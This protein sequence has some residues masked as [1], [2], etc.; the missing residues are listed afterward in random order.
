MDSQ[1]ENS[2]TR[3]IRGST[4]LLT[5]R[6]CSLL[7]NFFTQVLTVRYLSRQDYGVFAYAISLV[8]LMALASAFGM[9]KTFSQFAAAYHEQ[10]NLRRLN[11]ALIFSSA[12]ILGLGS[13]LIGGCWLGRGHLFPWLGI[14]QEEAFVLM[15]LVLL[16]PFGGFGSLASS[17]FAVMGETRTVFYRRQIIGPV[18][19]CLA[20]VTGITLDGGLKGVALAFLLAGLIQFVLDLFLMGRFALKYQLLDSLHR[21]RPEIPAR[22]FL[23]F[24]L[25]VLASD[26][27]TMICGSLVIVMVGMFGGS[28]EAAA[29][30]VVQPLVRLCELPPVTFGILF[31]PLASRLMIRNRP[32]ELREIYLRTRTWVRVLTFPIFAVCVLLAEPVIQMLFGVEYLESGR[33]M[34]ILAIGFYV[35][36]GFG[37][38]IQLLKILRRIRLAVTIDI[39]GALMTLGMCLLL[40]PQWQAI[41]AAVGVSLG[42]VVHTLLRE[43]ALQWVFPMG[44]LAQGLNFVNLGT[45]FC[46]LGVIGLRFGLALPTLPSLLLAIGLSLYVF[47]INRRQL[48]VESMFPE[49][50]RFPLLHRLLAGGGTPVRPETVGPSTQR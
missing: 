43:F 44:S 7:L 38:N 9:D 26:A 31:T 5:G 12:I 48:Q 20:M 36:A 30:R 24:G 23:G 18:L 11:G 1:G 33:V 50:G 4:L 32:S 49:L 40:I 34:A 15:L 22:E 14:N 17:F 13:L 45:L 2:S 39:L 16:V 46:V 35:E 47:L 19:K 8:E 21:E 6:G 3:Q 41:G 29:F 42:M 27:S 37:F 10:K 28:L 25:P